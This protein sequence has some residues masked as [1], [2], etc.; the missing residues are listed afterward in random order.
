[1]NHLTKIAG[2]Y[3]DYLRTYD[4]KFKGIFRIINLSN[5]HL[6]TAAFRLHGTN[7]L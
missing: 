6:Y 7:P 2:L 1:M 5:Q 3:L 4:I